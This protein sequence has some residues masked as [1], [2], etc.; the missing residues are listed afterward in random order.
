MT[1]HVLNEVTALDA[2]KAGASLLL[3]E[4][5]EVCN[6][7]TTISEPCSIAQHWLEA[8]SPRAVKATAD[9]S[10]DVANTLF[11]EKIYQRLADRSALY[12][13]YLAAHD[14]AH[15]W[16]SGRHAWGTYFERLVRFPPEGVN[17][18][19]RAIEKLNTWPQRNTTGLVFH[20]S[21][22]TVDAPR[23]RGGPCWHFGEILWNADESLDLVVVYRNHD[24]FNK[25]L[26]NF[27]GL[28][29]LLKFICEASGKTPGKLI[30][31][32]VHAY[33]DCSR[34]QLRS[35]IT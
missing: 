35:L 26:G 19:E 2:W 13:R 15:N 8:H 17:Q 3:R 11:P 18:L 7:I 25:V 16:R 12:E 34:Q 5:G 6:L 29:H 1:V 28:G 23:T 20:L 31:H 10:R 21:S 27:V 14:R 4:H 22:P 24:Y 33:F 30:C 32:S 9:D